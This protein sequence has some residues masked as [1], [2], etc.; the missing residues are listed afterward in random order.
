MHPVVVNLLK[1]A[2]QSRGLHWNTLSIRQACEVSSVHVKCGNSDY[3][4]A[5]VFTKRGLLK[6]NMDRAMKSNQHQFVLDSSFTTAKIPQEEARS[7]HFKEILQLWQAASGCLM[8]SIEV[9][10]LKLAS[11]NRLHLDTLSIR[12]VCEVSSVHVK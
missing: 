1:L 9:N 12:Q 3:T 2:L 7:G 10:L 8:H 5:D 11:E 4:L 6:E